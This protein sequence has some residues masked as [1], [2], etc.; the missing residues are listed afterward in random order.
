MEEAFRLFG[1]KSNH[2]QELLRVNELW[3]QL[4]SANAALLFDHL[5]SGSAHMGEYASYLSLPGTRDSSLAEE[6]SAYGRDIVGQFADRLY[7]A[8]GLEP[9]PPKSSSKPAKK[10]LKVIITAN[11]RMTSGEVAAMKDLAETGVQGKQLMNVSFVDWSTVQ[12]FWNQ[13]ELLQNTDIMVTGIG[14]ALFYSAFLPYGS[15]CINTGWKDSF[16]VPTFGEEVLGMSNHRSRFLYMPLDRVRDGVVKADVEHQIQRAASLI[17]DGFSLP[18][19][20]SEENLSI[21]GRIIHDLGQQSGSSKKGLQGREQ[22]DGGFL[23]HQRPTGQTS[24]SEAWLC[25]RNKGE[26]PLALKNRLAHGAQGGRNP[27]P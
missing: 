17:V 3:D 24:L 18:L 10:V 20:N 5:V 12:P 21:F 15:V 27:K 6:S 2:H 13:L 14:T 11:K 4:L 16:L 1:G 7:Q 8:H 22:L 23:C 26:M 9:P 19:H 25:T